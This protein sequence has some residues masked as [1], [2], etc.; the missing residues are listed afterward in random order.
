[1]TSSPYFILKDKCQMLFEKVQQA[2]ISL[3]VEFQNE[4]LCESFLAYILNIQNKTLT[5]SLPV[6]MKDDSPVELSKWENKI[7]IYINDDNRKYIFDTYTLKQSHLVTESEE[8]IQTML[9][10]TPKLVEVYP[11]QSAERIST[12]PEVSVKII[13]LDYKTGS[14]K[15][16]GESVQG[17]LHNLSTGGIGVTTTKQDLTE[18]RVGDLYQLCFVPVPGEE[19]I[20][21]NARLRHITDFQEQQQVLLGFQF[22]AQALTDGYGDLLHRLNQI[23]KLYHAYGK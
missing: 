12:V 5:L 15:H 6:S 17:M 20:I 9:I 19:P 21:L 14:T 23:I 1:M 4:L 13:E 11:R 3:K 18:I 2:Y 16:A 22:T 10:S 8:L 7:T